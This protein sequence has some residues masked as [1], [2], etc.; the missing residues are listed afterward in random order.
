MKKIS[1]ESDKNDEKLT[2]EEFKNLTSYRQFYI[3]KHLT[4]SQHGLY[5]P[6]LVN[7]E[8][9]LAISNSR[10]TGDFIIPMEMVLS[11][12]KSE[13]SLAR[14]LYYEYI[15]PINTSQ[16]KN[17]S[18]FLELFNDEILGIDIEKLRT[19]FRLCFGIL[20]KIAVA[21]CELYDL[22]PT[23]H[24]GNIDKKIYFQNFWRL[25]TDNRREKFEKIKSPGI[26][27]LYS[28]ATDLNEGK[29]GELSFYK[30]W[31]NDL[32]HKFV[33]IH[34]SIKPQDLY[35]SYNLIKDIIFINKEDFKKH[36]EQL[37]QITR[38]TIF[39]FVF[40]FRCEGLTTKKENIHYC[41][42]QIHS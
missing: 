35:N 14:H 37:I 29:N 20:D 18:G 34:K 10:V 15:N 32:E 31:R 17:E 5:C 28:I 36:F 22:Y 25:D 8:D 41:D 30:Q 23:N 39:S 9:N 40:M 7:S 21:I 26:L 2:Q 12:L 4:L 11:R 16:I 3:N 33:V 42:Q 27:A 13:S 24:K 19:T 1:Y 38:S 6:C